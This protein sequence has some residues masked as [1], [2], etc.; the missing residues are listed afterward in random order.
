M[1]CPTCGREKVWHGSEHSPP[2]GSYL[3]E[4]GCHDGVRM[5]DDEYHEGWQ[6]DV[7][8]PPCPHSPLC[9]KAC[10]GDGLSRDPKSESDDCDA[11]QGSG[12]KD[13]SPQWPSAADDQEAAE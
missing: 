11:C 10:G 7:V 4:M 1:T 13:N 6:D 2:R 12:W 5:D 8:Y 9:C 3:S